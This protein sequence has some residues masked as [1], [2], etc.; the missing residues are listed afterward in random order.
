MALAMAR[1]T[2][3]PKSGVYRVRRAVPSELR[4]ALGKREL[5][6]TLDTKDPAE[7]KRRAPPVVARFDAILAA[8][9]REL[10]GDVA[11][12]TP[13]EVA[14]LAGEVYRAETK[15]SAEDWGGLA[16]REAER[17]ALL[18]RLDGD[19]GDGVEDTRTFTPAAADLDE[20]RRLLSERGK[21]TDA[22]SL[23]RLAVAIFGARTFA[24]DVAVRRAA[25][26]WTPD[27]DAARFP[28]PEPPPPPAP[29]GRAAAPAAAPL[30][31][32]AL[33]AAYREQHADQPQKTHDKRAAKLRGFAAVAGHTDAAAV[34]RAEVSRWKTAGLGAGKN[35]KTVNDGIIMLRPMWYW[36]MREGLLP[37]GDNPFSNMALKATKRGGAK[38][39][40]FTDEEAVTLL[41]AAR[42]ETGFLRWL[43]WV[44]AWTGCRL[45][46]ACGAMRED[47]RDDGTMRQGSGRL[48]LP[49][50]RAAKL[51]P[52]EDPP[53]GVK[54]ALQK[55]G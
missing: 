36:A 52:Q 31:F 15:R 28:L 51:S 27:P 4:S 34:T 9:R 24:A 44:L 18:D 42:R 26:D 2:K 30:T 41:Q 19:Y 22:S 25:G 16:E 39:R 45:E 17:D 20:A 53:G 23:A 12:L 8:A 10:A 33:L 6:Q 40:G 48:A 38:R 37:N 11:P 46:E 50:S 35:A 49:A 5:I 29:T 43:P 21:V 32:D 54:G 13:R 47:V 14:E 7:A 3:H 1:P 55:V